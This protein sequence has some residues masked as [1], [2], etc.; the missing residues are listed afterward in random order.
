MTL[1]EVKPY[2]AELLAAIKHSHGCDAVRISTV[3]VKEVFRGETA[4]EGVVDVFALTGH[5]KAK[6]C[7]AWAHAQDDG[8]GWDVTTVLQLPPVD[9]PQTAVRIAL[10]SA[11]KKKAL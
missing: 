7:Y 4:W 5:P 2:D 3:D 8:K 11:A 9:S 1:L 10:A 6:I